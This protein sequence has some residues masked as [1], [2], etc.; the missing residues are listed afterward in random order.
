MYKLILLLSILAFAHCQL[1]QRFY[2][3]RQ[4]G[5]YPIYIETV[6]TEETDTPQDHSLEFEWFSEID[7]FTQV[8]FELTDVSII[9]LKIMVLV[10]F[11]ILPQIL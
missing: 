8:Y 1:I 7:K 6:E 11:Y 4:F 2:E 5:D 9:Y 10:Y 3:R